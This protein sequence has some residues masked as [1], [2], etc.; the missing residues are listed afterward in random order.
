MLFRLSASH[1]YMY[2]ESQKQ[3]QDN[4]AS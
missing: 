1:T 4:K 3:H 2:S